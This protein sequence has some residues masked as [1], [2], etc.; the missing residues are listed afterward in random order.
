M[1]E[2]IEIKDLGKAEGINDAD[3]LLVQQEGTTRQIDY[4]IMRKDALEKGIEENRLVDE[5]RLQTVNQEVESIKEMLPS[6]ASETNKLVSKSYVD[7]SIQ[8]STAVNRG[9]FET[10]ADLVAYSGTVTR[11]D[12]AYVADDETHDHEAWRY[13]WNDDTH[14]WTAEYRINEAPMTLE[15]LAALNSGI[16]AEILQR[17]IGA[18]ETPVGTVSLYM[19]IVAPTGYIFC[20]DTDYSADDYPALWAVLPAIVKNIEN[21]TFRIDMR[22]RV[23]QGANGNLGEYI[24]AGL[25]NITGSL[26]SATANDKNICDG[27]FSKTNPG[28]SDQQI[29]NTGSDV[30]HTKYSLDASKSNPIYGNSD[31]VQMDALCFNYI[32]KY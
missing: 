10:Y 31:T 23:P 2:G 6:T 26:I 24:E 16:T 3:T 28:G 30:P 4:E 1:A 11:N 14:E 21:R 12:Y 15:Q 9:S 20:D 32:I 19:G 22:D 18:T 29:G 13:K 7:E 5:E 17:L 8:T 27:A 25:P